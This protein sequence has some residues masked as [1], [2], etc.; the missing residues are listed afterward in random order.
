M[1]DLAKVS[2]AQRAAFAPKAGTP[3]LPT[4]ESLGVPLLEPHP[5][6]MTRIAAEWEKRYSR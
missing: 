4:N 1:L 5:S 3:G 2:T 6:W